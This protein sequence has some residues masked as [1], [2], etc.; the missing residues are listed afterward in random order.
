[1]AVAACGWMLR[2]GWT[3]RSV[4]RVFVGGEF[5]GGCDDT[6]AAYR[7]GKL[8]EMLRKAG[9]VVDSSSKV[10]PPLP[11]AAL[12]AADAPFELPEIADNIPRSENGQLPSWKLL[13]VS[14]NE[15]L[16]AAPPAPEATALVVGLRGVPNNPP[17]AVAYQL[18]HR[19]G[20]LALPTVN[21]V[22]PGMVLRR[23]IFNMMQTPA[24]SC[25][26]TKRL[27]TADR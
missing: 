26:L 23:H 25:F 12:A 7:S 20:L 5:V 1:M 27:L 9:A 4:P 11:S 21:W 6:Q 10:G 15:A 2:R 8:M 17:R 3:H 13:E 22:G 19:L 16:L 14:R 18:Q 24:S